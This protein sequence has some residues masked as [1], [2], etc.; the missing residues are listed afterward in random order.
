M[1]LSLVPIIYIK[2]NPAFTL[3]RKCRLLNALKNII[4]PLFIFLKK[5]Q[6]KALLILS[7]PDLQFV[8]LMYQSLTI[9][10]LKVK[11]VKYIRVFF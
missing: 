11:Q 8:F 4:F 3:D 7:V 1:N 6:K 2:K 10:L 5:K 9:I